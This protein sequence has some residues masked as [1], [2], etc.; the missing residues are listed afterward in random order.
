MS[1]DTRAHMSEG[2]S[3]LKETALLTN[4][5]V[6][7]LL[8]Q[9]PLPTTHFLT[10]ELHFSSLP[11]A[12]K[13]LHTKSLSFKF[14]YLHRIL[15]PLLFFGGHIN[16]NFLTHLLHQPNGNRQRQVSFLSIFFLLAVLRLVN[17][18]FH[19]LLCLVAARDAITSHS[20]TYY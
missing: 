11:R 7:L 10:R 17:S 3:E 5:S 19:H 14:H 2:K 13:G 9:I 20:W 12:S 18:E 16:C 15:P 1:L 4:H 6:I 8:L